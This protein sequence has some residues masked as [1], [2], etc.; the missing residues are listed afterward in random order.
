MTLYHNLLGSGASAVPE[1]FACDAFAI[2]TSVSVSAGSRGARRV[3][4]LHFGILTLE[5]AFFLQGMNAKV[6]YRVNSDLSVDACYDLAAKK[7]KVGGEY[8]G[9]VADRKVTLEA[10]FAEKD[11]TV[12]GEASVAIDC[13]NKATLTFCNM[14]VTSAKYSFCNNGITYEPSYCLKRQAPSMTVSKKEGK[15]T[16]KATYN[17][18]DEKAT[19]EWSQNP[20]KVCA[21]ASA[22]QKGLGKPSVTATWEKTYDF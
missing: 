16:Y 19:V 2:R 14:E 21:S 15:A 22:G 5:A 8:K 7:Y 10:R 18:K 9:E 12:S 17:V 11:K 3:L 20:W 6:A 4:P 1:R 13:N